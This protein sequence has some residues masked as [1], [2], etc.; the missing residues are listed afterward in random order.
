MWNVGVKKM[1][2]LSRTKGHSFE[3]WVAQKLRKHFPKARRHLEYQDMEA[4][5]IDLVETGCFKIQC[6][7]GKKYSSLTAIKEIQTCPVSGDV[8]LLVT[9]GDNEAPLVAMHFEDFLLLLSRLKKLD[10]CLGIKAK[11]NS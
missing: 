5:G 3:R 1:G 2:K 9:K 11:P 4:N 10:A 8:P 6:K 7:R